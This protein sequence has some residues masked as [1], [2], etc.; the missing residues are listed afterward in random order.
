[1]EVWCQDLEKF[2]TVLECSA[3]YNTRKTCQWPQCHRMCI[4]FPLNVLSTL[5]SLGIKT[6]IIW[7]TH[8]APEQNQ[9][10]NFLTKMVCGVQKCK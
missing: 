9:D 8:G 1:M 4:F 6:G 2:H 5:I 10:L 7:T 3:H